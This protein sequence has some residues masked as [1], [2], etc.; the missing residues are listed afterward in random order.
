MTFTKK[1]QFLNYAKIEIHSPY[2]NDDQ[3]NVN[4]VAGSGY[5]DGYACWSSLRAEL[6]YQENIHL[7][8]LRTSI[9]AA[10]HFELSRMVT[11]TSSFGV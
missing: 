1:I 11:S 8:A 9:A 5:L 10:I 6:L 4:T 2:V 3:L 7:F